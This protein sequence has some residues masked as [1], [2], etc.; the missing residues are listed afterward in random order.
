MYLSKFTDYSFRALIYL[1]INKDRLCTVEEIASNLEIS[2]NHLKKIIHK[3]AKTDYI[4]SIKGRAGGLK[5]G[6]EPKDINLGEVLKVTEDN[7]NIAECF[8]KEKTCPFIKGGCK[9]KGIMNISLKSFLEEFSKY[10]L[11]DVL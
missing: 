2:E 3:L 11:E 6:L 4:I 7:L 8:N 5:L 9:L 1:A 10:T